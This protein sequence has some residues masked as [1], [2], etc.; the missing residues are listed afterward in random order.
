M[1]L[2][3]AGFQVAF[4]FLMQRVIH[5]KVSKEYELI[6]SHI[7]ASEDFCTHFSFILAVWLQP[8]C[9]SYLQLTEC[10]SQGIT[11]MHQNQICPWSI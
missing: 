9:P 2:V 5:E 7:L 3:H 8:I 1:S 11:H 6:I 4:Q 10:L